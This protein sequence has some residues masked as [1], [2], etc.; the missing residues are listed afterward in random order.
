[1]AEPQIACRWCSQTANG[2]EAIEVGTPARVRRGA[3]LDVKH[4]T[5]VAGSFVMDVLETKGQRH[6]SSSPKTVTKSMSIQMPKYIV[7]KYMFLQMCNYIV[8]MYKLY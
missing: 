2:A 8:M 3:V 6:V 5:V 4:L 7:M 1:M